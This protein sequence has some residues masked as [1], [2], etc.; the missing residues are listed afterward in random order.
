MSKGL[1]SSSQTIPSS[2]SFSKTP[3]DSMD[4]DEL[5]VKH[6]ISEI[7]IIQQ[8]LRADADAKQEEL[9][10]MVGE[11]YRDLLQASTSIISMANSSRRVIEALRDTK[12]AI[13]A[14]RPPSLPKRTL[15]K[16]N[17]DIHLQALQVLAAHIKLLL[18]VPEH[19]WRMLEKKRHFSAA[20]LYLLSRVVHRALVREE[21]DEE[22]WRSQGVDVMESF[23]LVQRQWEVVAQFRS[24][25]IHKATLSLRDFTVSAE[26]TCATLLS[27]HL[28]D[29]RP[30][31][32]TL[33]AL[34]DQR[35]KS[36]QTIF[37][38]APTPRGSIREIKKCILVAVESISQ[39]VHTSRDVF[40]APESQ[41]SLIRATLGFIQTDVASPTLPSELQLTTQI[42]LDSLSSSSHF[43]ALPQNLR[44]YKPHVDV[45]SQFSSLPS[46]YLDQKA[47]EWFRKSIDM[48]RTSCQT[49]LTDVNSVK[50][51]WSIRSSVRNWLLSSA[52]LK[53]SESVRLKRLFDDV[54]RERIIEI[55]KTGLSG[56]EIAFREQLISTISSVK[57]NQKFS[58]DASHVVHLFDAPPLPTVSQFDNRPL[59][60]Y[61][62]SL[63]RQLIGRVSLLDNVLKT[64]EK[65]AA[66]LQED[67]LQV[68]C[69]DDDETASLITQLK[70]SY[71]PHAQELCSAALSDLEASANT[72]SDQTELDINALIFIG[73]VVEELSSTSP[74]ISQMSCDE[75]VTQEFHQKARSLYNTI[76]DRWREF[77][78]LRV[79]ARHRVARPLRDF[80]NLPCVSPSTNLIESLLSLANS[81]QNLGFSQGPL[82]HA[83]LADRTT[84]LFIS[85]LVNREWEDDEIQM[86]HDM[87]F[88]R[89]LSE[90]W[91]PHW[92][93]VGNL[94]EVKIS[95]IRELR[96]GL[97]S[98]ETLSNRSADCL[99]RTQTILAPV[100]PYTAKSAS[101]DRSTALL[102]LGVPSSEQEYR[103]AVEVARPSSRFALLLVN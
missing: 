15:V 48:L 70:E 33:T 68:L 35:T 39:T 31:S 25:I 17:E 73:R 47:S 93:D 14:E 18:E 20:W 11:R 24:Q 13:L 28:L 99:A 84:H 101:S 60:I 67:L 54:C 85:R 22:A 4:P 53:N 98:D 56:A 61:R 45:N 92:N 103:T 55:W 1:S 50:V 83:H 2:G 12:S 69:G 10:L 21:Q 58:D 100:L 30:L 78:V 49:W 94:L 27:L 6:N 97:P 89:K 46:A 7:K 86:L 95:Q 77:V 26:E 80:N 91:G 9:R 74:F 88:L 3:I 79:L 96:D 90:L 63:Q 19:L 29:S 36:L 16:N 65:C 76:I 57:S 43:S 75:A 81:I 64:L 38:K 44:S 8:R 37:S 62:A 59:Q 42:L 51:V 23:P 41:L 72:L 87:A 71:Q 52:K 34:L 82:R 32:D 66:A 40:Q 102:P 5:F